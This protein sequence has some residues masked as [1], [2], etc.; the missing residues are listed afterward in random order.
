MRDRRNIHHFRVRTSVAGD[1]E[2][3]AFI[4]V[5]KHG[6]P[7]DPTLLFAT[8]SL[9]ERGLSVNSQ[10]AYLSALAIVLAWAKERGI[11]LD[12]RM[13]ECDL[14]NRYEIYDLRGRLKRNFN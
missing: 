8:L 13:G 12:R 2:R 9:R 5:G 7:H 3:W 1:G 14:L 11:D 10:V 6:L 4:G